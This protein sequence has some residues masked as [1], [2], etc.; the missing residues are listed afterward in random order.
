[1]LSLDIVIENGWPGDTD[2]ADIAEAAS[3]AACTVAPEIANQ[4]LTADVL[5][6]SDGEVQTLNR[7][8]RTKDLPTNVLSFPM[9][10]RSELLAL[11]ADGGPEMLGDIALAHETCARQAADKDVA[12]AEHVAHLVIHG[13]LHLAGHDHELGDAEAQAMEALETKALAAM[14]IA[15]PYCAGT[16]DDRNG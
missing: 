9:L 1:M 12:L 6:T 15:N 7:E 13:L 2:W 14:G 11:G 8:W 3:E 16:S 4:R 10:T 5:F